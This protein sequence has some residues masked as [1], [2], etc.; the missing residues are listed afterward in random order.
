MGL[1][2]NG[3]N[4]RDP[5]RLAKYVPMMPS[6]TQS[7]PRLSYI[8]SGN[9]RGP[10]VLLLHGLTDSSF[11]WSRL[12]PHLPPEWRVIAPDQRGH[13]DSDR[14]DGGYGMDDFARDAVRILDELGIGSAA[15][16]GHSM[17]TFVARRFA[18]LAPDRVTRLTLIASGPSARN[19]GTLELQR[20]V[21]ALT[22]PVDPAFIRE[23]QV[24]T[25]HRG[26]P[27]DFLERVISESL[28]VPA[29]VFQAALDGM[30]EPESGTGLEDIRCPVQII[31]GDR[32]AVFPS[33]EAQQEL[34]RRIPD[35]TLKVYPEIGHAPHWEDPEHVAR[36]LVSFHSG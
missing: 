11:S 25:I 29:R 22:D 18:V 26:V 34:A 10:A 33:L 20:A 5:P 2:A 24:G 14:P 4:C 3:W 21:A 19:E 8:T 7:T 35:A 9:P 27:D 31:W 23:F 15:V 17:G 36:D 6:H 12:I 16:V 32:D 1:S 13:G 28:R 30:L